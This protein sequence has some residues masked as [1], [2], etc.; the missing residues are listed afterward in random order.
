MPGHHVLAQKTGMM[1]TLLS[2]KATQQVTLFNE[3]GGGQRSAHL[4]AA[5]DAVNHECGRNTL[6]AV[7][8]GIA[9]TWAMR[10]GAFVALLHDS[11]GGVA[12]CFL[13]DCK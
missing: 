11:V 4:M 5:M 10:S 13:V 1:L 9:N 8:S 2:D 3:A 6:R 7:A 12:E